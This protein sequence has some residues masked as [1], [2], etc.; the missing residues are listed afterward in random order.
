MV[1]LPGEAKLIAGEIL[2]VTF[3]FCVRVSDNRIFKN[4]NNYLTDESVQHFQLHL[5]LC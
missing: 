3:A 2:E 4:I 5:V 1:V